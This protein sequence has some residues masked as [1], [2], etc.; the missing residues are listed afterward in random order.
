MQCTMMK[1]AGSHDAQFEHIRRASIDIW[2][3]K[4]V[5]ECIYILYT[6]ITG[7]KPF[8]ATQSGLPGH[9][10]D[11]QPIESLQKILRDFVGRKQHNP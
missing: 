7:R 5:P 9:V 4:D 10:S 1:H 6:G 3:R 11:N 2:A 8:H